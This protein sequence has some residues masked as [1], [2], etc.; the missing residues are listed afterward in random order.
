[1]PKWLIIILIVVSLGIIIFVSA[2]LPLTLKFVKAK[3]ESGLTRTIGRPVDI[4]KLRGNLFYSVRIE[5]F[6]IKD[7]GRIERI[8]CSYNLFKLIN[9]EIHINRLFV[10]G[11]DI[12][13]NQ[14][15]DLKERL[16]SRKETE[17]QAE[18]FTLYIGNLE[19]SD[20]EFFGIFNDKKF[21]ANVV[22]EAKVAEDFLILRRLLIKSHHSKILID[23][24]ISLKQGEINLNYSLNILLDDFVPGGLSGR[25]DACGRVMGD[26]QHPRVFNESRFIIG[27]KNA[28]Y[29]GRLGLEWAMPL[30]DSL[31][32]N[33]DINGSNILSEA[34][35]VA[36]L[37]WDLSLKI[38]N[39]EISARF[40]SNYGRVDVDGALKGV[41]KEPEFC[42]K[43]KGGFFYKG[44]N[45]KFYGQ[46][47]Y[48]DNRITVS[49]FRLQDKGIDIIFDC[50]VDTKMDNQLRADLLIACSDLKIFAPLIKNAPN[51][52]GGFDIN[53][54]IR[55]TMERP[56][57]RARFIGR[58]LKIENEEIKNIG[59][60]FLYKDR[61]IVVKNGLI[62]S[63]RGPIVFYA[64]YDI[65]NQ[66]IKGYLRSP[67]V[68]LGPFEVFGT[69]TIPVQGR[70][71]FDI[72]FWGKLFNPEVSGKFLFS[73]FQYD[74]LRFD[75]Y[76]L[77]FN[78]KDSTLKFF[79]NNN[80]KSFLV[81]GVF[82]IRE[83]Y[84]FKIKL[85]L[86]HFDLT[87]YIIDADTAYLCGDIDIKGDVDHPED[88]TG[89][90]QIDTVN[91]LMAK[92]KVK[93]LGA[94]LIGLRNQR[95]DFDNFHLLVQDQPIKIKGTIPMLSDAEDMNLSLSSE[96]I[97][98]S[99][100]VEFFPQKPK[101]QGRL[102][103]GVNI[104][105][106]INMPEI[107]GS[108]NFA[109]IRYQ[110]P[111]IRVD[112]VDGKISFQNQRISIDYIKGNINNGNFHIG[113][114]VDI[115][116]RAVDT[117]SV[118][119]EF[120]KIDFDV[121]DFGSVL[122]TARVNSFA[123]NDTFY[124]DGNVV[125]DRALYCEP[126]NL[127][128]IVNLLT[129]VNRPPSKELKVLKRIYCNIGVS[130]RD[131]VKISNNI[132]NVDMGLNLQIKG[133][134]S[135]L[136]VSGV[137]N[138]RESGYI[139][140]LGREF[141]IIDAVIRFDN[142]YEIDPEISLDASH[143]IT[144]Q[145]I[146]YEIFMHLKGTTKKWH[147]RLDSRPPIPEPDIVSLLVTGKRRPQLNI[148]SALKNIEL[149]KAG[150]EYAV[151]LVRGTIE[152]N[153]EKTL[154]LENFTIKGDLIEPRMLHFGFERKIGPRLKLIYW[155]GIEVWELQS[156]G[157]NYDLNKNIS[158]FTLHDQESMN[159]SIDFDIHFKF[160]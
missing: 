31:S 11:I 103:F 35:D 101:V 59:A 152:R 58:N 4:H 14:V 147:L 56:D 115:K 12:D 90:V 28:R 129:S 43:L 29:Q 42:G 96:E 17:P 38:L 26:A 143:I 155:S 95:V 119:I 8:E 40:N 146:D 108:L 145:D 6:K 142:P 153:V 160:R 99:D 21:S 47:D 76:N 92:T 125:V 83:S 97:E 81:D 34:K 139:R 116:G 85:S 135:R 130:S 89:V 74:T 113:G 36:F 136:N 27:N 148:S 121:R 5:G 10:S 144:Y 159:S 46:L 53:A 55:G 9:K 131:G 117:M 37:N 22:T 16:A 77:R 98:L 3:I 69:D 156:I 24:K 149:D 110:E 102:K 65:D 112:S 120:N 72:D 1:M 45:P 151:G 93:S 50:L 30:L 87:P 2:G 73:E 7:L 18:V 23:G 48:K 106:S 67:G 15:I 79:F 100:L 157:L 141:E 124:I 75:P 71:G 82:D 86:N 107:D 132:A 39:Q 126:F 134:A 94:I 63:S 127:Q 118:G 62:N 84:P 41:I 140:Y 54:R 32:L 49:D 105:G 61:A 52:E 137:I 88:I 51:I 33:L 122:F 104:T 150:K 25:V 60:V 66:V 114:F 57:A 80:I 78:L 158:I 20:T 133:Y 70:F 19:I 64:G 68:S 138:T 128:K 44:L 13:I 154:N 91:F 123:H 109:N 111:G